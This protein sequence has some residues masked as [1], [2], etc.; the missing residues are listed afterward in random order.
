MDFSFPSL[1][2]NSV[3][4]LPDFEARAIFIVTPTT[5]FREDIDRVSRSWLYNHIYPVG[6]YLGE[7]VNSF[8]AYN[9]YC[10]HLDLGLWYLSFSL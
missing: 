3:E 8:R 7:N 2:Y 1:N 6:H 9:Y 5:V 10:R 4:T